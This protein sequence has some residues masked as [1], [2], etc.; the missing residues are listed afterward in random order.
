MTNIK[1]PEIE[2]T[3]KDILQDEEGKACEV[4]K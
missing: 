3:F 1:I 2:Q 4:L